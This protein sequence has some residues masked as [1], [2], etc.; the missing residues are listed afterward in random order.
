MQLLLWQQI[1]H[2]CTIIA[3]RPDLDLV[4]RVAKNV[5]TLLQHTLEIL[6]PDP[7]HSCSVSSSSMYTV[8]NIKLLQ[9]VRVTSWLREIHISLLFMAVHLIKRRGL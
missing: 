1:R 4:A 3:T 8:H 7:F 2:V 5:M 9:L 6:C